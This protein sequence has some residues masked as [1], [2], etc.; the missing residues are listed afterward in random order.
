M[1][2]IMDYV[3]S[4]NY[5]SSG[6]IELRS[7]DMLV[8]MWIGPYTTYQCLM[9]LDYE[10]TLHSL[11]SLSVQSINTASGCLVRMKCTWSEKWLEKKK[12]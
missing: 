6:I 11:T 7:H 9:N 2:G 8:V 10:Y 12:Q 4:V 1:I 5:K 3:P